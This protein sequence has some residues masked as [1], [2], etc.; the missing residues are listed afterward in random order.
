MDAR[1]VGPLVLPPTLA[2]L[3]WCV[4]VLV[5]VFCLLNGSITI[6]I[7]G[8]HLPCFSVPFFV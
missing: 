6:M 4:F 5:A 7:V 1:T 8:V 2:K 3:F